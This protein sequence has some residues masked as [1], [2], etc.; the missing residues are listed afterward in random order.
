MGPGT[1]QPAEVPA[2]AAH[3][4]LA[5][6]RLDDFGHVAKPLVAHDAT[7]GKRAHLPQGDLFVAIDATAQRG[8]GVVDMEKSEAKTLAWKPAAAV[9]PSSITLT[10]SEVPAPPANSAGMQI[11]SGG[12]APS[13]EAPGVPDVGMSPSGGSHQVHLASALHPAASS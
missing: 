13:A 8:L 5:L 12:G 6:R 10:G 9:I 11:G 2:I 1:L 3:G 7:E 4:I